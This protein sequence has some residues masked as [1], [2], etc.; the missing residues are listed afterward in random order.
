[1][2][3]IRT[4]RDLYVFV[5]GVLQRRKESDRT[6][7][8]YLRR[9]WE[10]GRELAEVEGIEF[11]RFAMLLDDAFDGEGPALEDAVSAA[12][13]GEL[14][15]SVRGFR[16]WESL[17]IAQIRDLREMAAAGTLQDRYRLFG[18]TAP[19][20]ARW[21]N[22]DPLTFIECGLAGTFGGWEP[23]DETGRDYVAGPVAV[24]D[25][26]GDWSTVDPHELDD[27]V[28][29][30]EMLTWEDFA[31]FLLSGQCYE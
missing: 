18:T 11:A 13:A 21:F 2:S 5:A 29:E 22:F 20:G 24:V 25:E 3:T 10:L 30:L 8:A 6:L 17:V 26:N 31:D 4:N 28:F 15:A 16:R 19:R 14:D 1:M 23:G 9:L 7:E 12:Q 27:S